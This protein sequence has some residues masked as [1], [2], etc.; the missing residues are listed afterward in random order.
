MTRIG[1]FWT[2]GSSLFLAV[3][4]LIQAI[5]E[6]LIK[7][8]F[9]GEPEPPKVEE[10]PPSPKPDPVKITA[11]RTARIIE[12]VEI[13]IHVSDCKDQFCLRQYCKVMKP[14]MIHNETCDLGNA[15]KVPHCSSAT[16]IKNHWKICFEWDCPICWPAKKD[17]PI[18]E[19]LLESLEATSWSDF[20]SIA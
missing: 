5:L 6:K 15:C 16:Q 7:I 10:K 18:M 19:E 9:L 17:S 20:S 2:T 8:L 13:M 11:G 1:S 3:S 4:L 12:R 14:V